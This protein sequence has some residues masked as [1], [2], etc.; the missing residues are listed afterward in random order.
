[1]NQSNMSIPKQPVWLHTIEQI[2]FTKALI[3]TTQTQTYKQNR[4]P[5]LTLTQNIIIYLLHIN[6]HQKNAWFLNNNK[7]RKL[8]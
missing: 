8:N 3:W 1:M 2:L 7:K 6:L 5:S 4:Y